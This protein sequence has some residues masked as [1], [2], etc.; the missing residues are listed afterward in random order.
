MSDTGDGTS[1]EIEQT[2]VKVYLPR[3]QKEEWVEHADE[4]DM[5]QSEFVRTMVQ[6]GRRG[7]ELDAPDAESG[8][9]EE[10]RPS[11]SDPRG[12]GLEDRVLD[13]LSDEGYLSWD[14]LVAALSENFENRLA[15]ALE[16]LQAENRVQHS[17]R[18]GGYTVTEG[19]DE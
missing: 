7:F 11:G 13:A 12:R 1:R 15:D 10:G 19:A 17:G 4:L 2:A 3:Y 6:A 16:T 9:P 5:N 18:H 14:E 8:G